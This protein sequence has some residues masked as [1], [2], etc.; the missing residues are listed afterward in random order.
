M[1]KIDIS[2]NCNGEDSVAWFGIYFILIFH[3]T[4]EKY[5]QI[6]QHKKEKKFYTF[7]KSDSL[8]Q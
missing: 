1:I 6:K 5:N 8:T 4:S 7:L 2:L 3:L